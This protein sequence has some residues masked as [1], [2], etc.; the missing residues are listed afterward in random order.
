MTEYTKRFLEKLTIKDWLEMSKK[1]NF[2]AVGILTA[3]KNLAKEFKQLNAYIMEYYDEAIEKVKKNPALFPFAIKDNFLIEGKKTTAASKILLNFNSPYSGTIVER[4][5]K[6]AVITGK[7]NLDPFAM[8]STGKHSHFGP[9]YS[10][11]VD[12]NGEFLGPGGSSSGSAVAV[13]AGFALASSGTDTG[14]SIRVPA[15]WGGFVGFKPTY[16]A[17]SRYGIVDFS[18]FL[19]HPGYLTKTV[20]DCKYLFDQTK[21][22]DENDLT[23]FDIT[24]LKPKKKFAILDFS[25]LKVNGQTINCDK[26]LEKALEDTKNFYIKSGYECVKCEIP[27][28]EYA[29]EIYC[30]IAYAEAASN[31]SRYNGI[32]YGDGKSY[33]LKNDDI[34]LKTRTDCF[35][36]QIKRRIIIGNY[37][38][39]GENYYKIY[40]KAMKYLTALNQQFMNILNNCDF[41]LMPATPKGSKSMKEIIKY[42]DPIEEILMDIFTCPANYLGIPAITIPTVLDINGNPIGIQLVSKPMG[43]EILFSAGELIEKFFNFRENHSCYSNNMKNMEG[44]NVK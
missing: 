42:M 31:L 3:M 2:D 5:E 34:F 19:D 22:I 28:I 10:P 25:N 33:P 29:A 38:L 30:I 20:W 39:Y 41:I 35:E 12:K 36:N 18:S 44:K 7:T 8:G 13:S 1:P 43:E 32:F 6:I 24:P 15:S 21:G 16:G 26:N 11:W 14:G 4:L 23:T 37:F 9:A 27:L 17:L 40:Q